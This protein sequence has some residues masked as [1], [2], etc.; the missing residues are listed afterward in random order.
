MPLRCVGARRL[1]FTCFAVNTTMTQYLVDCGYPNLRMENNAD[2]CSLNRVDFYCVN[3]GQL[4][5][6]YHLHFASGPHVGKQ[7]QGVSDCTFHARTPASHIYTGRA[8]AH[9]TAPAGE[10]A[11]TTECAIVLPLHTPR[12]AASHASS[13]L[14]TPV[15][16]PHPAPARHGIH[17]PCRSMH[18]RTRSVQHSP[19]R[20]TAAAHVSTH[21]HMA[22]P[23]LPLGA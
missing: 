21:T 12:A 6:R 16:V 7:Q 22:T 5:C 13:S 20:C 10:P 11:A 2:A 15:I 9:A 23:E 3:D 14:A 8:H 17:T 19:E 1:C 4:R 18:A